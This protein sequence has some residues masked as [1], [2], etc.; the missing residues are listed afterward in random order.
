[1]GLDYYLSETTSAM[2]LAGLAV[3]PLMNAFRNSNLLSLAKYYD[4]FW[5]LGASIY[6][7]ATQKV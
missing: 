6:V 5:F 4:T 3:G 7:W 2:E 1:M